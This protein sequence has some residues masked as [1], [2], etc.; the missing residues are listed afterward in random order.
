MNKDLVLTVL[1]L[2]GI[3]CG[4]I[5]GQ[6]LYDPQWSIETS[7]HL[8]HHATALAIFDF[9]GFDIFMGLLKML[10]VPLIAASV[11]HAVT[12]LGDIRTLGRLGIAAL[13]YYFLTMF[14]AVVLGL[15]LVTSI[16][17]GAGIQQEASEQL[18]STLGKSEVIGTVQESAAG[19]LLGVFK[20][21]VG[22][23]IPENVIQ[24]MAE[25]Q[26]LSLIVFFI[27]FGVVATLIGE[28]A[29]GVAIAA[30]VITNVLMK[31]VELVLWLSPI[32]VFCLLAWTVARIGLGVFG[33][34]IGVYMLTVLLGL[35][36][37]ALV[38]LP[39]ILWL[40]TRANPFRYLH[41]MRAALMMAFGT[42]SSS[43][44]LPVT[45]ESATSEGEVSQES[46]GLVLPLGAT[47]NMD[48]TALYEAVA[49][50]FMAQA[51]GIDLS[52]SELAIIAVTATLAAVGAAGIPSAGLV[53]MVIV[54]EAVNKS[55]LATSPGAPQIPIEAVGLVIGVDRLLDMVRTTVNVWGDSVGAKIVSVMF[56]GKV[57][58]I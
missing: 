26:T 53:T 52:F 55:L 31:M 43:A 39:I 24:A 12:S 36:L 48:G 14:F 58:S 22:L 38:V 37:H 46:A 16:A 27:F 2:L 19:G 50:V 47:I 18:A 32:G 57:K 56:G 42:S 13:V 6:L 45:I 11:L 33:D 20:N 9:L 3:V 29:K 23:M 54:L 28:R 17:P 4:A 8:H 1:I 34:S 25:G 44:T 41:Q 7:E 40:L 49:V 30:E 10:I 51:C 15:L 35:G 21:L 5:V